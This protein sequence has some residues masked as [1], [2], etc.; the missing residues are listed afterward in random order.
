VLY[1][2]YRIAQVAEVLHHFDEPAGIPGVEAYAG[3]VQNVGRTHQGTTQARGQIDALGLASGKAAAE[4][5]EG[6]ITKAYFAEVFQSI[7]D[8]QQE[9]PCYVAVVVV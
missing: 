8:F 3:F 7:V 9:A 5:V 6:E 4:A 2:Y 1:Y